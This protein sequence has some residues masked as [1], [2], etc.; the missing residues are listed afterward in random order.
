MYGGKLKND[1]GLTKLDEDDFKNAYQN[2]EDEGNKMFLI[3]W[4]HAY[5]YTY[6]ELKVKTKK[7]YW[8]KE[9]FKLVI[10]F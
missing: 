4:L 6:K 5:Q 7:P 9:D 3:L 8:A 2:E 1:G 10:W